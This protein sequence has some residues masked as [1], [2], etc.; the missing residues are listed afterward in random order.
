MSRTGRYGM[1]VA[2]VL[3]AALVLTNFVGAQGLFSTREQPPGPLPVRPLTLPAYDVQT[4]ENGLQVVAVEHHEQPVI[5]IRLLVGV[6][7]SQDPDGKTG[8]ASLVASLLD[9]GAAGRSAQEIATAIDSIGGALNTGLGSDLTFVSSVVMSDSF[10]VGLEL[11]SEVVRQPDFAAAEISRQKE[12]ASSSLQVSANDPDYIASVL[13]DR[14]V[15]GLHPYGLPVDGTPDTLAAITLDD[16]VAFHRQFFVPNNVIL[17]VVGDVEIAEAVAAV[18]R[19][20][21]DWPRATLPDIRPVEPPVPAPRLVVVDLPGSVQTE[22]RVGH[23]GIAR[24]HPDYMAFDLAI[25]ILGGEGGNRLHRVLRNERGLT[26]GASAEVNAQ[27]DTGYLVAETDTRTES[28]AEVLRLM[29]NEFDRIQGRA[30]GRGEL[31][32]AQAYL[33]GNFPLTVETPNQIATQILSSAFY[34][35]PLD[36]METYRDRVQALSRDDVAAVARNLI[37]PDRLSI[38][39]VG[40]A[41]GFVSQLRESGFADFEVIPGSELDLT[42]PDLRRARV[43]ALAR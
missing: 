24:N 14:L 16:L 40:D 9:Q 20:F 17:A 39:L 43:A 18:A 29:I 30:V 27:K 6:G 8:L 15:F 38:V 26:Y 37:Y 36:E 33:A 7:A 34:G 11:V 31:A 21:G 32:D 42:A 23:L 3:A 22:V 10:E 4:L 19:V 12:Q 2:A 1:A 41:S 35:L 13:F 25:K 28:T 5:S